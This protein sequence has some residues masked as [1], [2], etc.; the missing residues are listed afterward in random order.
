MKI[1][2][3]KG[4]PSASLTLPMI[5]MI[6]WMNAHGTLTNNPT[7]VIDKISWATPIPVFPR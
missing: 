5:I 1:N 6:D 4:F 2:Q 3:A 7:T